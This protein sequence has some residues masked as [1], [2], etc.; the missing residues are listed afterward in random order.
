MHPL[1]KIRALTTRGTEPAPWAG[2]HPCRFYW[3]FTVSNI[4]PRLGHETFV[5]NGKPSFTASQRLLKLWQ[6]ALQRGQSFNLTGY[7]YDRKNLIVSTSFVDASALTRA[8]LWSYYFLTSIV[9]NRRYVSFDDMEFPGN[10]SC[11]WPFMNTPLR[12]RQQHTALERVHY[13]TLTG[14]SRISYQYAVSYCPYGS[15]RFG[16]KKLGLPEFLRIET[17]RLSI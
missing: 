15:P 3:M 5:Y 2:K 13:H 10:D 6:E 14:N 7:I 12:T 9:V 1:A 17:S 4:W 8:P 16:Y 11:L